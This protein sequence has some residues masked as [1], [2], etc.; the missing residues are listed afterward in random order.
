MN[1]ENAYYEARQHLNLSQHAYD[2]IESDQFDFM[3]KPSFSGML[4][5]VFAAY[6]EDAEAAIDGAAG[7]YREALE[8]RLKGVADCETKR[9]IMDVLTGEHRAR[10]VAIANSYDRDCQFK[11]QLSRENFAFIRAWQDGNDD[12]HGSAGRFIK[13]V[14]EEYAAK[15]FY[16]RE[17][18]LLR[19]EICSLNS[20]IETETRITVTTR[21]AGGRQR[22]TVRPYKIC[23]DRYRAFHYLAGLSRPAD[24]NE[25]ER[26]ASFRLSRIEKITAL[27]SRSGHI[28]A[29]QKKELDARLGSVGIQ[30]LLQEQELVCVR[31]S[32]RGKQMLDTQSSLRPIC[33]G[34]LRLEDG[35][36]EYRFQC[37]PVQALYYFFKFGGEAAILSPPALR[38][39][40]GE[41][42]RAAAELYDNEGEQK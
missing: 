11:F 6:R 12:Y 25:A 26:P 19:S 21:T 13:A 27:P 40:F 22:F 29:A 41:R 9:E 24:T 31:L 17:A 30:F 14:I 20:F 16:E 42:Y 35:S 10:C 36:W 32:P 2:V 1:G 8:E 34:R 39:E 7:R 28:T 4:N 37:A 33:T 23:T 38:R 5:K 18:I 3:A 15:P